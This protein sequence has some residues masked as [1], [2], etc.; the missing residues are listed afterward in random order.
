MTDYTPSIDAYR[1]NPTTKPRDSVRVWFWNHGWVRLTIKRGEVLRHW[2]G[3]EHEEGYSVTE[4]EWRFDGRN[5]LHH[6]YAH[7]RDCDGGHSSST[8]Y[9]A[10]HLLAATE[11][12]ALN[13]GGKIEARPGDRPEWQRVNARQWD[14]FAELAGY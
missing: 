8:D 7:G 12:E 1:I 10:S 9:L 14:P 3:G 11:A 2:S 13:H 6:V 5:I 4:T